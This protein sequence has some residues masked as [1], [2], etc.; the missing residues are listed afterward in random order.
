MNAACSASMDVTD[1]SALNIYPV[2]AADLINV[3]INAE[4]HSE[5][6]LIL[7]DMRGRVISS[8]HPQL[9]AGENHLL[10]STENAMDGIY[11]LTICYEDKTI[12]R[13]VSVVK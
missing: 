5:A 1:N 2:P 3:K 8:S 13:R 11:I 4:K 12:S 7:T 6:I 10:I 9:N